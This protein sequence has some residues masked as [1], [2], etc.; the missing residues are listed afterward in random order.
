LVEILNWPEGEVPLPL[1][2]QVA[3]LRDQ[4]WPGEQPGGTEAGHDPVLRPVSLLLVEDGRVLAA[5]DI[6]SKELVHRDRSYGASGLA[7]VVTLR[8]ERRRGY[9]LLLVT[10]AREVMAAGGADLAIFTCDAPLVC[11]YEAGGYSVLPGTVLV[12]GT[13]DDP[14]TSDRFDKVTLWAPFTDHA[15]KHEE[16]FRAARVDLYPG[17]IDRLW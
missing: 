10:A 6:L 2:P 17:V 3:A 5:L 11:F 9:G 8:A 15:W 12:G 7:T 16:D 13:P 1:R 4:A 14:F